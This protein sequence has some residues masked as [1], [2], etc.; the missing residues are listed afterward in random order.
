MFSKMGFEIQTCT[1][2]GGSGQY[3]Y[4]QSY[5]TTCFKCSG[6]KVCFTAKGAAASAFYSES[7]QVPAGSLAVGDLIQIEDFFKQVKYFA[8]ITAIGISD[9]KRLMPDGTW[10]S[11]GLAITTE[12]AKY[13]QSGYHCP[14]ETMIR[15]GWSAEAKAEKLAAAIAYQASLTKAGTVKKSAMKGAA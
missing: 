14:A 2:C 9:S 1:R 11:I 5:G 3:S 13:G 15:K 4:C 6:R 12:H 8:P 7:L 10:E